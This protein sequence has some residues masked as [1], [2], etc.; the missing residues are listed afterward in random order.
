MGCLATLII[1]PCVT[2]PLV[3]A[4]AYIATNG[5]ILLGA[6]ALFFM[7]FGMGIPLLCL[8]A[9]G[10]KFLPKAGPWMEIIRY[11]LGILMLAVALELLSRIIPEAVSL[12]LWGCLFIGCAVFINNNNKLRKAIALILLIQ[13][14]LM[15]SAANM[16]NT[17]LLFTRP[18]LNILN[19]ENFKS[20]NSLQEILAAVKLSKAEHRPVLVDFYADWCITCKKMD[21]NIFTNPKFHDL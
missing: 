21:K 14:A 1:S 6:S 15:V 20:V 19:T 11:G 18:L 17:E 10:D 7:G 2:P 5:N 4:L 13:G 12:A 3:G 8:G 9:L 16:R